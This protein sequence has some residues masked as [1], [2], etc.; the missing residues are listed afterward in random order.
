M[1]DEHSVLKR[2]YLGLGFRE[3]ELTKF[4]HLP[5]V[6]CFMEKKLVPF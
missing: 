6:V 5:F 2:W 3:T 4:A 1:M